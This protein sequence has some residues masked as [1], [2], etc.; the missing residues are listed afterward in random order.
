MGLTKTSSGDW[1]VAFRPRT[2]MVMAALVLSSAVEAAPLNIVAVG[3]SNTWGWGVSSKN[4]YPAKMQ[5][6]LRKRGI[7][8]NDANAGL[9]DRG[10]H[11]S[12]ADQWARARAWRPASERC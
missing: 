2:F 12:A 9:S 5:A 7:D 6:L 10:R 11:G 4:A 8:A 3:A 1:T